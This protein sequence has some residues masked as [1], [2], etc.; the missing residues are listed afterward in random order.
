MRCPPTPKPIDPPIGRLRVA[1]ARRYAPQ[2]EMLERF[3][4][5]FGDQLVC[6]RHR[7]RDDGR[8]RHTTVELLIE[9]TPI[10]P[11]QPRA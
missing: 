10:V 9:S 3:A 7:L 11:R 1:V 2:Q 4:L 6:V 8:I 5:R